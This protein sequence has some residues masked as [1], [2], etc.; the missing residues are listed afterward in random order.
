MP[1]TTTS[2]RLVVAR[3][4]SCWHSCT[5]SLCFISLALLVQVN[6]YASASSATQLCCPPHPTTHFSQLPDSP[7]LGV[8]PWLVYS[9][10]VLLL[11]ASAS[12]LCLR[13][14]RY[15]LKTY[16]TPAGAPTTV[17]NS[18]FATRSMPSPS[19]PVSISIGGSAKAPSSKPRTLLCYC[20]TN[21][22]GCFQ[23][24]LCYCRTDGFGCLN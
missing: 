18:A 16:P 11:I 1:T 9:L 22:F 20:R 19:A 10:P 21:G 23:R 15:T 7:L 2:Q 13:F 6:Y 3:R 4:R 24:R 8:K 17:A 14:C 5:M 12:V